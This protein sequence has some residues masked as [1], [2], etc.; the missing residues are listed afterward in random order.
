MITEQD[1]INHIISEGAKK[2]M[3]L[4]KLIDIEIKEYKES[5]AYQEMLIGGKYYK[6][7]GEILEKK[8]TYINEKVLKKLHHMLKTTN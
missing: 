3:T 6:N 7:E 1:R 4:S 2:G 8:R 5:K